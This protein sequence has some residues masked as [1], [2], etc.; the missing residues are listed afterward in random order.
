MKWQGRRRSSNVEDR[1]GQ[2]ASG[3]RSGGGMGGMGGI[4]MM[5]FSRGG[6]KSKLIMVVLA[7]VAM[8]VFKVSPQSILGL[9]GSGGQTQAASL[10]SATNDEMYAYLSTM[11]ADNED[12]WP[13]IFR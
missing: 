10:A 12:I 4:L 1:R 11:K 5:L 6:G 2:P 7:V 9:L 8:A 13:K 3:G